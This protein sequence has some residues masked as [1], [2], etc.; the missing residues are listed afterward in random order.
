M[1]QSSGNAAVQQQAAN[2]RPVKHS[3]SSGRG[4][5][6]AGHKVGTFAHCSTMPVT[7]GAFKQLLAEVGRSTMGSTDGSRSSSAKATR[8]ARA[9]EQ[10]VTPAQ[11][12]A[13]LRGACRRSPPLNFQEIVPGVYRSAYPTS[14]EA[15]A[16]IRNLRPRTLLKLA[17]EELPLPA[18]WAVLGA[19]HI[20]AEYSF[21]QDTVSSRCGPTQP[22]HRPFRVCEGESGPVL[23]SNVPAPLT[24][25]LV[26]LSS[27]TWGMPPCAGRMFRGAVE[28]ATAA[29]RFIADAAN[30]PIVLMCPTGSVETSLVCAAVR[31]MQQWS[32][33]AALEEASR[34]SSGISGPIGEGSTLWATIETRIYGGSVQQ[35]GGD[36]ASTFSPT[37]VLP[38]EGEIPPRPRLPG[39]TT[40]FTPMPTSPPLTLVHITSCTPLPSPADVAASCPPRVVMPRWLVESCAMH[41]YFQ[42][43]LAAAMMAD[44]DGGGLTR[45]PLKSLAHIDSGLRGGV[46]AA[47]RY[48]PHPPLLGPKSTFTKASL[49]EPED[50]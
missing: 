4:G 49:A 45:M 15:A 19:S 27:I 7:N 6:A 16:Y 30:Y 9:P 26:D 28:L 50:D 2:T 43:Q 11:I 22:Q 18:V 33:S 8:S 32:V 41:R 14:V 24:P 21:R 40:Q 1:S 29:M 13:A 44:A 39:Y 5:A 38:S 34:F 12:L 3:S 10:P 31:R 25:T 47:L 48:D 20:P 35:L 42:L 36:H 46:A 23:D 17:H 37:E